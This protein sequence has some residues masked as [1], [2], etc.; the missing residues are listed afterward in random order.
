[1]AASAPYD[2]RG[3]TASEGTAAMD[4]RSES[5]PPGDVRV[6]DHERD[7]AIAELSEHFQAG[8]LTQEEFGDRSGRALQA[9]TGSDLS[10]LFTDLPE[11]GAGYAPWGGDP[12]AGPVPSR[13]DLR[14]AG[15][16]AAVRAVLVCVVATIIAGNVLGGISHTGFGWL[17]PVVIIGC[18]LSR[19]GRRRGPGG[20]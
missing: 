10:E 8:R 16:L 5:F 15:H 6:S 3:G 19:L 14:R 9:R 4:T 11:R 1:M 7:Q 18:V 17:V 2:I 20:S 13:G 12:A